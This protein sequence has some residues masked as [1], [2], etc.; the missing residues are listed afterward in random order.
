VSA[1]YA[2]YRSQLIQRILADAL[3]PNQV[4]DELEAQGLRQLC[5]E[6]IERYRAW[7]DRWE[8][9][10]PGTEKSGDNRGQQLELGT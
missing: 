8:N 7:G 1:G 10:L 5:Y 2:R 9:G 6:E 3:T 4:A